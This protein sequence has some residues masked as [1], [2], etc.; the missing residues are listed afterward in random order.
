MAARNGCRPFVKIAAIGTLADVVPLVGENRVIA[1]LG[2]DLLSRGPH[3]VGLQSLIDA[4]G[5]T[6]KRIDSYDVSFGLAPR[7]ER[8]RA[9]EHPGHRDAAPSCK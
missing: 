2:L 3:K 7:I 6:G 1:R 8:G 5:L 9:D 4:A